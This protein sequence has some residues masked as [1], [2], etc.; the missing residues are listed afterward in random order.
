MNS[1]RVSAAVVPSQDHIADQLCCRDMSWGRRKCLL[2]G[3]I[4]GKGKITE[5]SVK[6]AQRESVGS[7]SRGQIINWCESSM[8]VLASVYMPFS[9]LLSSCWLAPTVSLLF[10]FAVFSDLV[11]WAG[12]CSLDIFYLFFSAAV[13]F[14]SLKMSDSAEP[15]LCESLLSLVRMHI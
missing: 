12:F 6:P 2:K 10:S 9:R 4:L 15:D 11:F 1:I 3:D 14:L 5:C 8:G 7:L 13:W